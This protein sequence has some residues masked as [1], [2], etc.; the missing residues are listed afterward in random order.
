MHIHYDMEKLDQIARDL[1][2]LLHLAIL[3]KPL[4]R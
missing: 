2:G 4:F 3:Q 1:F